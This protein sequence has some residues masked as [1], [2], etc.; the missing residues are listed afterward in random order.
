MA[1]FVLIS[2]PMGFANLT[3]LIEIHRMVGAVDGALASDALAAAYG[4]YRAGIFLQSV[5]W[6]LRLVALGNLTI[7][8][9]FLP[10]IIGVGLILA[11]VG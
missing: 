5:P 8:S 3:A 1:M 4:R 10:R 11:G 6:G 7:R 2:V 9:G